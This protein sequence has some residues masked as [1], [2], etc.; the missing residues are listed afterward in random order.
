MIRVGKKL[1]FT[2]IELLVVIVVIL[3]LAGITAAMYVNFQAQARDT[4]VRDA[5]TKFADAI[6]LYAVKYTN[7]R[8]PAGGYGSTSNI[9]GTTCTNGA[10]GWQAYGV[11][12]KNSNYMCTVGD[13]VVATGYLTTQFFDALPASTYTNG[14][15]KELFMTA[16]CTTSQYPSA[17][18]LFYNQ[19]APSP[20]ETETFN[21]LLTQCGF[22]PSGAVSQ[23]DTYKMHGAILI[24]FSFS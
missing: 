13:A 22:N 7:G 23:R 3:I 19:E 10:T 1:G 17:W 11:Y 20:D 8:P 5:A 15:N 6:Q 12:T 21:S 9:S 14:T 18:L 2:I 4:Q 24:P 16:T